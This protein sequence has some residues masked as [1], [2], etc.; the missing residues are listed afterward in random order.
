MW[1]AA[2][3][4]YTDPEFSL[5]SGFGQNIGI[6][7]NNNGTVTNGTTGIGTSAQAPPSGTYGFKVNVKF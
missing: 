4:I 3:N 7:A 1:R 2:E 6:G 5:N